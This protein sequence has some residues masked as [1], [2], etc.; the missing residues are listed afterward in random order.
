M[1]SKILLIFFLLLSFYIKSIGQEK[2]EIQLMDAPN[3]VTKSTYVWLFSE[4]FQKIASANLSSSRDKEILLWNFESQHQTKKNKIDAYSLSNLFMGKS[5]KSILANSS[6]VIQEI[7]FETGALIRT[8]GDSIN[9]I[10]A[11]SPLS[12]DKEKLLLFYK[13]ATKHDLWDTNTGELIWTFDPGEKLLEDKGYFSEDSRY[14]TGHYERGTVRVWDLKEKKLLRSIR[15]ITMHNRSTLSPDKTQIAMGHGRNT[16]KIFDLTTGKKLKEFK[17]KELNNFRTLKYSKDGKYLLV[18]C[19]SAIF[20]WNLKTDKLIFK[21]D[22]IRDNWLGAWF[23][24]KDKS[25]IV[26]KVTR[27]PENKKLVSYSISDLSQEFII[28]IPRVLNFKNIIYNDDFIVLRNKIWDIAKQEYTHDFSNKVLPIEIESLSQNQLYYKIPDPY[29]TRKHRKFDLLKQTISKS[30]ESEILTESRFLDY[31]KSKNIYVTRPDWNQRDKK[32]LIELI[33]GETQEILKTIDPFGKDGRWKQVYSANLYDNDKKIILLTS[34]GF[35]QTYDVETGKLEEKK[36][37]LDIEDSNIVSISPD[38]KMM[39]ILDN[40]KNK[41]LVIDTKTKEL[42]TD[43]KLD[44]YSNAS[45]TFS[46]NNKYLMT[47]S[48]IGGPIKI[49]STADFKE[50]KTIQGSIRNINLDANQFIAR[51]KN[52]LDI[53]SFENEITLKHLDFDAVVLMSEYSPDKKFLFILLENGTIVKY[54]MKKGKI[55]EQ[56]QNGHNLLQYDRGLFVSNDYFT[57]KDFKKTGVDFYDTKNCKKLF[58]FYTTSDEDWIA[59]TPDGRYDGSPNAIKDM[60]YSDGQKTKSIG[61]FPKEFRTEGLIK[62]LLDGKKFS[63]LNIDEGFQK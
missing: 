11:Y 32:G 14:Y 51:T 26:P 30:S 13:R 8:Y 24:N 40:S 16:L 15:D 57:I 38:D 1:R 31:S 17:D 41:L 23:H 6:N 4:D 49:F 7:D 39:A 28:P 50:V 2:S 45:P 52:A 3:L 46:K 19:S 9:S 62:K 56:V 55:K 44:G 47:E 12:P 37:K 20:L 54:D 25:F 35:L 60:Y 33:N 58:T 10:R 53:V 34:Q 48:D 18:S 5:G 27:D 29:D 22:E 43:I 42:L 59:I 63:S 36:H 61:S 21:D